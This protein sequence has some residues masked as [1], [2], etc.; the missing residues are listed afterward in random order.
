[1]YTESAIFHSAPAGAIQTFMHYAFS[2]A[3]APGTDRD[4]GRPF[5]RYICTVANS[6]T[7]D[8]G[9]GSAKTFRTSVA[10]VCHEL[11]STKANNNKKLL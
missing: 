1:M 10:A 6:G 2:T 5:T 4:S 11:C 8:S 3:M 7:D 9:L